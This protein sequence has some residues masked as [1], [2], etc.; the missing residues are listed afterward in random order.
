MTPF[1][2]SFG[3]GIAASA[4]TTSA[5][6]AINA[7]PRCLLLTNRSTTVTAY[8]RAGGS[9]VVATAAD[10]AVPPMVQLLLWL[11]GRATH[12]A[13]LAAATTADIHVIGGE[14]MAA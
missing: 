8:F 6:S 3:T 9:D 1:I 4:T 7:G 13:Y 10:V 5:N 11:D 14:V 12:V 2:P